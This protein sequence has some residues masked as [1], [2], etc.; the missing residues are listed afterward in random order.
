LRD[1]VDCFT[2]QETGDCFNLEETGKEGERNN[3]TVRRK[4]K[5]RGGGRKHE[6]DKE[7]GVGAER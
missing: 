5:Y 4:G 7:K 1:Y 3:T 6:R 2:V